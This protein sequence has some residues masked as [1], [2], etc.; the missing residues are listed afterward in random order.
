MTISLCIRVTVLDLRSCRCR[1]R[2]RLR[3]LVTTSE[4]EN[5]ENHGESLHYSPLHAECFA[6][7][8][9]RDAAIHT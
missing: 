6:N 5:T 4:G 2:D 9:P 8:R 1:G 3:W 7:E